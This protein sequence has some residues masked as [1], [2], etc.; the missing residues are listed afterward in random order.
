M[1]TTASWP[2]RQP[3]APAAG[4]PAPSPAGVASGPA[5]PGDLNPPA[6]ALVIWNIPR[7]PLRPHVA[8]AAGDGAFWAASVNGAIGHAQLPHYPGWAAP[9]FS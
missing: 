7:L 9:S 1:R 4:T 6:G 3:T 2:P 8:I 5:H